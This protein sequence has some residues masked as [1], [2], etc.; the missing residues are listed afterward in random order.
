MTKRLIAVAACLGALLATTAVADAASK[1]SFSG[2][3]QIRV[4]TGTNSLA[5]YTGVFNA[6]GLGQGAVIIRVTPTATPNVFNSVA[7]AY[8]K[9]ATLTATG[10]TTTTTDASNNSTYTA[11]TKSVSGTGLLKGV[12]GK[13]SITGSSPG[14]DPTFATLTAKGTLTY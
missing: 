14:S 3:L 7:T 13:L 9:N 1:H 10:T 8:F 6:K 2:S 11:N 12:K 5:V 4:L